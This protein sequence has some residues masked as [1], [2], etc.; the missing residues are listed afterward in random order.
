MNLHLLLTLLFTVAV[1]LSGSLQRAIAL[2]LL[3][4]TAVVVPVIVAW[5]SQIG[6]CMK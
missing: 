5:I 4:A 6:S 3:G 2:L 1:A